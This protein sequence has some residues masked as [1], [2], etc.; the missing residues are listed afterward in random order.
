MEVVSGL[1]IDRFVTERILH[2]VGMSDSYYP[3]KAEDSR[4]ARIASLY[5]GKA[6]AWNRLWAASGPPM[7]P[8]AWGSQ[9]LYSTPSDYAKFLA[10]WLDGGT[11]GDKR[12]L[13][14]NAMKRILTPTSRMSMLGSDAKYLTGFRDA[15][16]AHYKN[17]PFRVIAQ[18]GRLAQD[19]PDQLVFELNDA[20]KD[21]RR[22]FVQS[23][24]VTIGFEKDRNGKVTA[25][26]LKQARLTFNLPTT[27]A[28]QAALSR[29]AV[30]KF[31]GKSRGEEQY[32]TVDVIL[33][34]G[35]LRVG[36]PDKESKWN[37]RRGLIRNR[38]RYA[39]TLGPCLPSRRPKK[40]RSSPSPP[41]CPAV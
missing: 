30:A 11:V 16:F 5:F 29:E 39:A 31:L 32:G 1:P 26:T 21:G 38:G 10:M 3:T 41:N 33:K 15:N 7:Y 24:K 18:D 40:A 2:P 28:N 6:T 27:P 23:D 19:I 4:R 34:E 8:F 9:T 17:V 37:W 13:S 14:A 36:A 20:D 12:I 22:A 35:T 25:L